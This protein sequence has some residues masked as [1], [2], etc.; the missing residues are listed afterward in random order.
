MIAFYGMTNAQSY[1]I[2]QYIAYVTL[3]AISVMS[4]SISSWLFSE[5]LYRTINCVIR[6]LSGA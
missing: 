3:S 4:I 2:P 5:N 1:A 6:A